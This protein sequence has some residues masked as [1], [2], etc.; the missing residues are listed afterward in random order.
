MEN[1][2]CWATRDGARLYD[3]RLVLQRNKWVLNIQIHTF[4]LSKS[5]R[6]SYSKNSWLRSDLIDCNGSNNA[7]IQI[8]RYKS[9]LKTVCRRHRHE[10]SWKREFNVEK[11]IHSLTITNTLSGFSNSTRTSQYFIEIKKKTKLIDNQ[12]LNY[13]S[14][15]SSSHLSHTNT[16]PQR[17][18]Y[19][20]AK[21]SHD[22]HKI[23]LMNAFFI[24]FLLVHKTLVYFIRRDW[25]S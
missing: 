22:F 24:I 2:D 18:A 3:V 4:V 11:F 19:T 14:H 15:L 21:I 23:T 12:R 16:C 6:F 13:H 17:R 25:D 9:N 8:N 1:G 10:T 20:E 7:H 5:L